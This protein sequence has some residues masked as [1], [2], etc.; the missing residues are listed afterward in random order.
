MFD[1]AIAEFRRWGMACAD[2]GAIV[3]AAGVA[4]NTFYFQFPTKEHILAELDRGEQEELATKLT[5]VLASP[6]PLRDLLAEVVRLVTNIEQRLGVVLFRELLALHFSP[7]R[8]RDSEWTTYPV[9]VLIVEALLRA[10]ESGEIHS[11][12]DIKH[13]AF[14]FLL[15]LYAVLAAVP[16]SASD[17]DAILTNFVTTVLRGLEPR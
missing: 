12:A 13:N 14:F 4:R 5:W 7:N 11:E 15:G 2:I 9:V 3:T 10:R 17:R 8:P 6:P 1:A 16:D